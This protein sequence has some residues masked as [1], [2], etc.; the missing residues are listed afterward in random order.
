MLLTT[1]ISTCGVSRF[2]AGIIIGEWQLRLVVLHVGVVVVE[3]VGHRV[4]HCSM[5]TAH[6]RQ[7]VPRR[8][9]PP[10][11]ASV[12]GA[13]NTRQGTLWPHRTQ[14]QGRSSGELVVGRAHLLELDDLGGVVVG[15][16]GGG[17]GLGDWGAVLNGQGHGLGVIRRVVLV[18][19]RAAAPVGDG[20][21]APV[22]PGH[23]DVV[24][25]FRESLF[26]GIY[27]LIVWE[28][29]GVV[30]ACL[31]FCFMGNVL[32]FGYLEGRYLEVKF[33]ALKWGK[34]WAR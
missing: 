26:Y 14:I 21:G 18:A 19:A 31:N 6:P 2:R 34:R 24:S 33:V 1:P 32:N 28:F 9:R 3:V 11:P 12:G 25:L 30:R 15:V 22:P 7:G 29:I 8:Q 4:L 10:L 16:D 23:D 5:P 27:F 20:G 13:E 17:V